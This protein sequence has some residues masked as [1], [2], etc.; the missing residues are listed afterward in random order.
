MR[1]GHRII[2]ETKRV[3]HY[4]VKRD[5]IIYYCK[6]FNTLTCKNNTLKYKL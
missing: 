3:S 1:R 4:K 2:E 5:K 6:C